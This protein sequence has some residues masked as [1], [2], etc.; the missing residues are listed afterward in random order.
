M[1]I[2]LSRT[3]RE[4]TPEMVPAVLAG[5]AA[6]TAGQLV[7]DVQSKLFVTNLSIRLH[8]RIVRSVQ[9][10]FSNAIDDEVQAETERNHHTANVSS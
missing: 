8:E 10:E 1:S 6:S 5:T 7:I 2:V 3:D 9:R 4:F